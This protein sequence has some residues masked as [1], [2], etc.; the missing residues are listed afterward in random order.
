MLTPKK[1]IGNKGEEL[2]AKFLVKQGFKIMERNY[3]RPWGEIDIVAKNKGIVHF[4][5]V[6]AQEVSHETAGRKGCYRPEDH[7]HPWKVKR[8]K[9]I[10]E[11]WIMD[12]DYEGEWQLAVA[13]AYVSEDPTL[14]SIEMFWDVVF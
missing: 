14:Q 6:K 5:E 3:L 8:F 7:M 1:I 9:R 12:K 11:T 10:I 4:I 2:V 13:I